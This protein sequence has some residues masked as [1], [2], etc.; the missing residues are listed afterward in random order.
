MLEM[1][2]YD[3]YM[4]DRSADFHVWFVITVIL[5]CGLKGSLDA[6]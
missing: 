3:S 4:L 2:V 5:S 6:L 1:S